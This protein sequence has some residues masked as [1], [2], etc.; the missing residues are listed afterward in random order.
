M[1]GCKYTIKDYKPEK[2]FRFFEE[3]SAIPRGSKNEAGVADYLERFAAER[4][5]ECYRDGINNVLI[6]KPA[7]PGYESEPTV[8]LQGHTDMV[9]EK[10]MDTPHDFASQPLDLYVEDGWLRARGTTLGADDGIAVAVMLALLD[11]EAAEHPALECLFTVEEETGLTGARNF[12]YSKISACRM[13]NMDSE[14]EGQAVVGCAGG[15]RTDITLPVDFVPAAGQAMS[16]KVNG[17]MGG[18]SGMDIGTG[19][20]NANKIMGRLLLALRRDTDYNLI[21]INGGLMENAIPRECEAVL[22][23]R[24]FD[25]IR[26][27]AVRIAASLASELCRDDAGFSLTCTRRETPKL[28]MNCSLTRKVAAMLGSINNGVLRMSDD[29]PGLVEYSRNLGVVRTGP[30]NIKF[31]VSTRSAIE[32]QID[33]SIDYLDAFAELCGASTIHY[34]RY[35]GWKYEK[36]SLMREKYISVCRRVL[37]REPKILAIHAGLECGIIKAALPKMDIVSIGPDMLNIHTPEEKL[38]LS[39]MERFWQIIAGMLKK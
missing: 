4:G 22:T 11:G 31:S 21:S 19:R 8:L 30:D 15:C 25:V 26:D 24:D 1:D 14:G 34:N 38:D 7:T 39:S 12:D 5:L 6:K 16:I 13:I 9:C 18:H 33:A 35:P 3:I 36:E 2:L 37:R 17:L 28:M 23:G 29:V 27:K 20:A 10:N 32:S